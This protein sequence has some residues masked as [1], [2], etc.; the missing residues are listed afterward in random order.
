M[1]YLIQYPLTYKAVAYKDEQV[2]TGP[3]PNAI[4]LSF[5][6]SYYKSICTIAFKKS[7]YNVVQTSAN[8]CNLYLFIFF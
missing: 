5:C 6:H 8:W 7:A 3:V 1:C 4:D 2:L